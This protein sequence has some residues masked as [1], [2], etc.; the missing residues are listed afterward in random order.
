MDHVRLARHSRP[1][2]SRISDQ[3]VRAGSPQVLLLIGS[4]VVASAQI[5]KAIIAAPM[6][7]SDLAIGFDHVG[8][9]VAIF[10]TLGAMTGLGIGAAV[11][12]LGIRRSL[13][14]RMGT[15]VLGNVIAAAAPDEFILLV[16]RIV[17]GA[18]FLSV[19][20]IIPSLLAGLVIRKARDFM[21]AARSSA[22][23]WARCADRQPRPGL[24]T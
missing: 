16:A 15:V 11:D 24:S 4:G 9:I 14:G 10:A 7:R 8:L 20:V 22:S 17:E 13:V 18:G 6:I 5:G 19:A 2:G 21:M 1:I 12:R 23:P 3:A